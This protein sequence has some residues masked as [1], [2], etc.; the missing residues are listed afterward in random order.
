MLSVL[1]FPLK[2]LL[3]QPSVSRTIFPPQGPAPAILLPEILH[4]ILPS[5][6][7]LPLFLPFQPA[8]SETPKSPSACFY[9]YHASQSTQSGLFKMQINSW[10][11]VILMKHKLLKMVLKGLCYLDTL[12]ILQSHCFPFSFTH[13]AVILLLPGMFFTTYP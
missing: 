10:H 11:R 13:T 4:Y 8:L 3:Y 12:P 2:A 5:L 6:G 7:K 1:H 9:P